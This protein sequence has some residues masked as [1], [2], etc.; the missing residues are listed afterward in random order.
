MLEEIFWIYLIFRIIIFWEKLY[1]LINTNF[2]NWFAEL[3][4]KYYAVWK[5]ILKLIIFFSNFQCVNK[6][7]TTNAHWK[8][9]SNRHFF[10]PEK[11]VLT[12]SD[13][14]GWS[15]RVFSLLFLQ[16]LSCHWVGSFYFAT[17]GRK[18]RNMVR[19]K[20]RFV[21]KICK[22]TGFLQKFAKF[23]KSSIFLTLRNWSSS[24]L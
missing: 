20:W 2:S 23:L 10:I 12:L 19:W 5:G 16:F 15:C 21:K 4:E 1:A 9:I 24:F 6:I 17:K 8:S 14:W 22:Q 3:A 18:N 13:L 7:F 11:I